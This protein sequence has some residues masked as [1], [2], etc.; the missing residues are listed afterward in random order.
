MNMGVRYVLGISGEN[1]YILSLNDD[2]SFE[3]DYLESL[4]KIAQRRPNSLIGSV[5]L[6]ERGQHVVDGGVHIN[7]LTAKFTNDGDG[8]L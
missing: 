6:A 7:W 5:A 3:S 1:D 8:Q 2:V 4:M